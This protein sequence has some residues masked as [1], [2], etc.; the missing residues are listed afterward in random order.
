MNNATVKKYFDPERDG[1]PPEKRGRPPIIHDAPL[2][3]VN[4]HVTR[5]KDYGD[6]DEA[7]K[8]IMMAIIDGMVQGTR[9]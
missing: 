1:E 9:F 4:L 5:M 7:D 3:A 8:S 6:V 2:K